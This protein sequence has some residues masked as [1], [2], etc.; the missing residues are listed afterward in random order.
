M[1]K[2]KDVVITMW[3]RLLG[4]TTAEIALLR[5]IES[6]KA[7]F[8]SDDPMSDISKKKIAEWCSGL[9]VDVRDCII[10]ETHVCIRETK[11]SEVHAKIGDEF[12]LAGIDLDKYESKKPI[13]LILSC[14]PVLEFDSMHYE[15]SL[16]GGASAPVRW[17]AS[18]KRP[19]LIDPS[20]M[21]LAYPPPP[22][23]N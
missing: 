15:P 2:L 7:I 17:H 23:I 4:K 18:Y 22:K 21:L 19:T 13:V 1:S 3:G 11:D 16:F 12:R 9:E 14:D 20:A 6:A 8:I 10:F 5:K